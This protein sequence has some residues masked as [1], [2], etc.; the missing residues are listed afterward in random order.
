M[1]LTL[2]FINWG[3]GVDRDLLE[4]SVASGTWPIS[5]G[6]LAALVDLGMSDVTLAEYFRVST[7]EVRALRR[8]YGLR[9]AFR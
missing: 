1:A 7:D 8:D 6:A 3:L 9:R 2:H 4:K 5:T